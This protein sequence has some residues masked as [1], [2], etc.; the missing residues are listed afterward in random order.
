MYLFKLESLET[1]ENLEIPQKKRYMIY[2]LEIFYKTKNPLNS[3][4]MLK[5]NI[6]EDHEQ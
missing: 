6:G 3:E 4:Q 5:P 1:K 2:E